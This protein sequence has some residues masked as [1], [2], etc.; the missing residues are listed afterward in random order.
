MRLF[1]LL[2]RMIID[3]FVIKYK[4]IDGYFIYVKYE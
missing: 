1:V 4:I 2:F 3:C